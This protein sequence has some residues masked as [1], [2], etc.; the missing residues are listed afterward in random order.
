MEIT[1]KTIVYRNTEYQVCEWVIKELNS[2]GL[3]FNDEYI[4]SLLEQ[5]SPIFPWSLT[6][7]A[8]WDFL[9][10]K[11]IGSNGLLGKIVQLD[12]EGN[13]LNCFETIYDAAM[14]SLH[15]R[16][17]Y[18][19]ENFYKSGVCLSKENLN[20][21]GIEIAIYPKNLEYDIIKKLNKAIQRC[22]NKQ[23]DK[24]K[25]YKERYSAEIASKMTYDEY[26]TRIVRCEA[27]ISVQSFTSLV[28]EESEYTKHN[29]EK[30]ADYFDR[31]KDLFQKYSARGLCAFKQIYDLNTVKNFSGIYLLCLPQIKGCY[32]GKTQKCFAK[33]ITQHFTNPNSVFDSKYKPNDIKEIY[34]LQL[35]E[36][37]KMIDFI[38]EDCIATLGKEI[39]LNAMAGGNSIELIK[40]E[41][42]NANEHLLNSDLLQWVAEDSLN[43]ARYR[44]E[45]K[46]DCE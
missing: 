40:S 23:S 29:I 14:A 20:F 4:T 38:E 2:I 5:Q 36:T 8:H 19:F 33:R 22:K 16:C 18:S 6:V 39:S 32:I 30:C 9:T 42:Y 41:K 3:E 28:E 1:K 21:F 44:E 12:K 25:W 27:L 31:I 46:E 10:R 45:C 24:S 13:V 37:M 17:K 35:D 43:I 26:I 15:N 7:L 34:V 11:F